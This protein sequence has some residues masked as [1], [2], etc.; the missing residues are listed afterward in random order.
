MY[1]TT[2][3]LLGNTQTELTTYLSFCEDFGYTVVPLDI[4]EKIDEFE[5]SEVPYLEKYYD[6]TQYVYLVKTEL[7]SDWI[8][9]GNLKANYQKI[10]KRVRKKNIVS[11]VKDIKQ[12]E[13][14]KILIHDLLENKVEASAN[15]D[16]TE[17]QIQDISYFYSAPIPKNITELAQSKIKFAE[18]IAKVN[19]EIRNKYFQGRTPSPQEFDDLNHSIVS[20]WP[21]FNKETNKD[22]NKKVK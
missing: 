12:N 7:Y 4:K 21:K 11:I 22:T 19:Q 14:L 3:E 18:W 20:K 1:I 17:R 13:G 2:D 15:L 9:S 5:K 8:Q 10:I 16:Y 6:P